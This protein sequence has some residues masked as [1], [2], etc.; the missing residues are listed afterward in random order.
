LA[1]NTGGYQANRWYSLRIVLAG[2][3]ITVYLD[4]EKDL[5][6]TDDTLGKGTFALYSWGSTGAKFRSVRWQ[7]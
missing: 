1:R 7:E 4:G 3:R 6:A 2:P 5:E